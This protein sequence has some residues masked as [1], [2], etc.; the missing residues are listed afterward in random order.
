MVILL[1]KTIILSRAVP[2]VS[3]SPCNKLSVAIPV[4]DTEMSTVHITY[5]EITDLN[6]TLTSFESERFTFFVGSIGE[7]FFIILLNLIYINFLFY[8]LIGNRNNYSACSISSGSLLTNGI[9]FNSAFTNKSDCNT[10]NTPTFIILTLIEG[11][12]PS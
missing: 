11:I 4:R 6:E 5:S 2:P 3:V 1:P 8:I 10:R 12:N 7:F 9:I